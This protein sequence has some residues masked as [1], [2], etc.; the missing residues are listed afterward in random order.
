M[1]SDGK[2]LQIYISPESGF[3]MKYVAIAELEKGKGIV[4]DRYHSGLGTFSKK[5]HGKPQ[6]E[7]TLIEIEQVNFFNESTGLDIPPGEFRR[8]LVTSRVRLN[9]LVGKQFQVGQVLLE[10]IKL[11]EP[12]DY[13]AKTLAPEVLPHL[14]GRGGLRAAIL[15]DGAIQIDDRI[16]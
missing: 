15:E 8:N 11:C 3:S 6:R 4:D 7:V 9:D 2:L 14:V 5:L 16:K 1:T 13:L 12:C 10:G